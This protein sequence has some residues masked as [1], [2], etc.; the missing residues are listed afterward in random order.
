MEKRGREKSTRGS[1]SREKAR[2]VGEAGSRRDGEG[3]GGKRTVFLDEKN[4]STRL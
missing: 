4:L 3:E 1:K 2:K